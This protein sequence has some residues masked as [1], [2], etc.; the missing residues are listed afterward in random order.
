MRFAQER[1]TERK[2]KMRFEQERERE[3]GRE[4]WLC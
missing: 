2:N 3:R 4:L 1:G